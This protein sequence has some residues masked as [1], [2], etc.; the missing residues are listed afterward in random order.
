MSLIDQKKKIE[1]KSQKLTKLETEYS[2]LKSDPTKSEECAKLRNDIS[3]LR[4]E[5]EEL[6]M[7]FEVNATMIEYAQKKDDPR[8]S[9]LCSSLKDRAATI[10]YRSWRSLVYTASKYYAGRGSKEDW[11]DAVQTA[12]IEAFEKYDP[13]KNDNFCAYFYS[14]LRYVV[15]NTL[16]ID[17]EDTQA[18]KK[19]NP[20]DSQ[21]K[22]G[23][24]LDDNA[25][26]SGRYKK[27]VQS[28]DTP[29][30]SEDKP[31]SAP[32]IDPS[33]TPDELCF[34]RMT[35]EEFYTRLAVCVVRINPNEYFRAFAAEQYIKLC[36]E[37]LNGLLDINENEAFNHV[38][39]IGFVDY[40]LD[41][42]C[43]SFYE[44]EIT[45]CKQY[46]EFGL[47][48][49]GNPKTSTKW[50]GRLK[51][52]FENPIYEK[53]FGVTDSEIKQQRTKFEKKVGIKGGGK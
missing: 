15:L 5:I 14:C 11:E 41:G 48:P 17:Y 49:I 50:V 25:E 46:S 30:D 28:V 6:T 45:P 47:Y 27:R 7:Q 16:R 3:Q 36:R 18:K 52:P 32:V 13:Q 20:T 8:N 23:S 19:K 10:M 21:E 9:A 43:R 51:I 2:V 22:N 26:K 38:M 35:L 53:F 4:R 37:H 40:T 33:L 29:K 34:A 12:F 39:N 24:S 31:H 42:I 44:I 1:S